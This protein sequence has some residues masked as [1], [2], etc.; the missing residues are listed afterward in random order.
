ME[1]K[2]AERRGFVVITFKYKFIQ[3]MIART[4]CKIAEMGAC[5]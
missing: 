5:S 3:V 2:D 4:H 1:R